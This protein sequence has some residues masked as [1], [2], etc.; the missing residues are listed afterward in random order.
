MTPQS[1]AHRLRRMAMH[2]P[3][4][5]GDEQILL[6]AAFMLEELSNFAEQSFRD[7]YIIHQRWGK[8]SPR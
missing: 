1:I 8:D 2:N 7:S 3:V 5:T 6:D 4:P